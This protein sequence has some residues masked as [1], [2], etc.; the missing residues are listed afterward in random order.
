MSS[1]RIFVLLFSLCVF[2]TVFSFVLRSS[3]YSG[4]DFAG[5][6]SLLNLF[7]VD[8]ENSVPTWYSSQILFLCAAVL[9]LIFARKREQKER[10]T[11]YWL[12][13]ALVFLAFSVDEVVSFHEDVV[14]YALR[15][16]F[17][18]SG[19]LYF[20]WVI[21]AAV[22]IS[23]FAL[24][25]LRLFLDLPDRTRWLFLI[26]AL[27]YIGGAFGMELVGG[28]YFDLYGPEHVTYAGITSIEEGMEMVGGAL[29]FYALVS[30]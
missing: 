10:Y 8:L 22:L 1:N 20:G 9:Y 15:S 14:G 12:G 6:T 27:M 2:F 5:L 29:F 30:C 19:I 26:A 13:L 18:L 24:V 11:R 3:L 7:D 16:A 23:F 4:I 21:P 28:Y 25:Y 17:G